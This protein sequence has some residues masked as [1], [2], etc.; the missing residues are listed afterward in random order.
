MNGILIKNVTIITMNKDKEIIENGVVVLKD[1]KIIDIGDGSLEN[2]YESFFVID[3][4]EGIL[5]PG[6]INCH[7]HVS[8][9]A[10]RSLGDD[11]PDRLKKYIFPLEKRLV[12]K[13]LVYNGARYGICEMLLSGVTTFCD[14]YYY[15]DEVARAANRLGIRAVL[16]ET[17]VDFPSPDSKEPYGGIQYCKEFIEKWHKDELITPAVAPHAPYT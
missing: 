16:G 13:E 15:E 3:G 7:S 9:I 12:D 2:K 14:M 8:M 11:E 4:N 6:M 1:K 5:M 10:F 17:I